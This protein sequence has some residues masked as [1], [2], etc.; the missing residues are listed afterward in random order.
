MNALNIRLE[1]ETLAYILEHGESQ[2]LITDREFSPVIKK[3]LQQLE[4]PPLVI[5][6]DDPMAEGGELLGEMDYE[7]F[8]KTGDEDF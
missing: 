5:D 1:A 6:I 3:V 8:L 4:D 2:V 7:E